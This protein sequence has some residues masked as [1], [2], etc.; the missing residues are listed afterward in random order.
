[1]DCDSFFFLGFFL[2]LWLSQVCPY[3]VE[4]WFK[5]IGGG[6]VPSLYSVILEDYVPLFSILLAL[7]HGLTVLGHDVEDSEMVLLDVGCQDVYI[8]I[9]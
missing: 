2:G 3:Y 8:Y 5:S 9:S 1:M 6:D 4:L 7:A